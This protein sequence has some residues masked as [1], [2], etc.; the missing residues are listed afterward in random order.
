M[1][2]NI[3]GRKMLI[4]LRIHNN[5]RERSKYYRIVRW[6]RELNI[7]IAIAK[8]GLARPQYR[9]NRMLVFQIF[10]PSTFVVC[11]R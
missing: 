1:T 3:V 11:R 4:A 5:V 2:S 9:L 6:V 8:A 10:F 7:V